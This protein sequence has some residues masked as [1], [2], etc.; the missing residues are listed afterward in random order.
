MSLYT[1]DEVELAMLADQALEVAIRNARSLCEEIETA[2]HVLPL[3][4]Q[5]AM[6]LEAIRNYERLCRAHAM[7]VSG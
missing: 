7:A 6:T 1:L 3:A 4:V 5:A 2:G